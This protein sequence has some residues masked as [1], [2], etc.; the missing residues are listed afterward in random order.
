MR[1][2]LPVK[3]LSIREKSAQR[4]SIEESKAGGIMRQTEEIRKPGISA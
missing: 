4:Q 1:I 2:S 3:P